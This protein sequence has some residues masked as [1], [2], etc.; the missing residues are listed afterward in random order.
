MTG[1]LRRYENPA[2]ALYAIAATLLSPGRHA[3]KRAVSVILTG[4]A[5]TLEQYTAGRRAASST[6]IRRWLTAWR[7]AGYPPLELR[8]DAHGWRCV[9]NSAAVVDQGAR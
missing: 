2:Q 7:S 3:S 8:V 4:G 1:G 5:T 6:T 9:V